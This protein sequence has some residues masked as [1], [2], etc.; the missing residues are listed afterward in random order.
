MPPGIDLTGLLSDLGSM[1]F[2]VWLFYRMNTKTV[3]EMANK[4]DASVKEQRAEFAVSLKDLEEKHAEEL[5][6]QREDFR[7]EVERERE[8]CT[9]QIDRLDQSLKDLYNQDRK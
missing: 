8:N 6:R 2:I 7:I 9:K 4:F 3:P 1:G 5:D